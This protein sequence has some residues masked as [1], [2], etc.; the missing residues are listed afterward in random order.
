VGGSSLM[1]VDAISAPMSISQAKCIG[2]LSTEFAKS[3]D[4]LIVNVST[5]PEM[6]RS[7][8]PGE[9]TGTTAGAQPPIIDDNIDQEYAPQARTGRVHSVSAV[10]VG[11]RGSPGETVA[12]VP[13][14]VSRSLRVAETALVSWPTRIVVGLHLRVDGGGKLR[15]SVPVLAAE[16]PTG[17]SP[18]TS[19]V[20]QHAAGVARAGSGGVMFRWVGLVQ[21]MY[22]S[23]GAVW[24]E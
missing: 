1:R 14:W 5:E 15:S 22:D 10:G 2:I 7:I 6:G 12:S 21:R 18:L 20:V 13:A 11:V 4:H 3:L 8:L 19:T 23:G 17:R 9:P 24:G 16:F